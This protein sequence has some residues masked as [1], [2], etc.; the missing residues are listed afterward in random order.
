MPRIVE[1]HQCDPDWNLKCF[2]RKGTHSTVSRVAV[3]SPSVPPWLFELQSLTRVACW[4]SFHSTFPHIAEFFTFFFLNSPVWFFLFIFLVK[5]GTSDPKSRLRE[6]SKEVAQRAGELRGLHLSRREPERSSPRRAETRH[7]GTDGLQHQR[8]NTRGEPFPSRSSYIT[9][10]SN[11]IC[12]TGD[13]AVTSLGCLHLSLMFGLLVPFFTVD[14]IHTHTH[15]DPTKRLFFQSSFIT[16]HL[17]TTISF[18][19]FH[20]F[21]S[22]HI[23]LK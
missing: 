14:N 16:L 15:E 4:L 21:F 22:P 17:N 3:W 1:T 6:I 7:R 12:Q 19:F 2:N 13:Y 10:R 20:T 23:F 8:S 18:F 9:F 11:A 5:I